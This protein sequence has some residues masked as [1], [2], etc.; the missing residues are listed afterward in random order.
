MN[1]G[2]KFAEKNAFNQ[3]TAERAGIYFCCS[4]ALKSP[5]DV[6]LLRR[7]YTMYRM[8]QHL[9]GRAY[10]LTRKEQENG[11]GGIYTLKIGSRGLEE[12]NELAKVKQKACGLRQKWKQVSCISGKASA[13]SSFALLINAF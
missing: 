12:V 13:R 6:L 2:V 5:Q 1:G 8:K 7:W 11:G 3:L 9:P 4:S 10:H